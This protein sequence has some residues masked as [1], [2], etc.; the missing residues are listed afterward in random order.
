M[1]ENKRQYLVGNCFCVLL[2]QNKLARLLRAP[3]WLSLGVGIYTGSVLRPRT[4]PCS[5]TSWSYWPQQQL[6]FYQET[7]LPRVVPKIPSSRHW[8]TQ[9]FPVLSLP[10]QVFLAHVPF[11]V[12]TSFPHMTFSYYDHTSRQIRGMNE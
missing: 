8:Q 6:D 3:S 1:L 9:L 12:P 10:L 4:P 2:L 5:L 7:G 11:P